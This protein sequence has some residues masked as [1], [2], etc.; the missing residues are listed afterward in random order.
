MPLRIQS[1]EIEGYKPFG[2]FKAELG[3]LEVI[4]G[5][6]SSGKSSLF[7]FLGFLKFA[8]EF[9]IP[10]EIVPGTIG[11]QI[12][13]RPGPD[14]FAWRVD[15]GELA[16]SGAV[17]GPLGAVK[18]GDETFLTHQSGA[19]REYVHA[20]ATRH[21][22]LNR[23]VERGSELAEFRDYVRAWRFY[24]PSKIDPAQ[25]RE[26]VLI[27]EEPE[28]S[29]NGRNLGAVLNFIQA[30]H[31]K[32]LNEIQAHLR[33]VIPGFR[34][35]AIKPRGGPGRVTL[36]WHEDGHAEPLTLADVSDGALRLLCWITLALHPE[37][38]PLICIDEPD[39]GAHPRALPL[40]AA[41]FQ[42]LSDRTQVLI[43]THSSYFLRQF[44]LSEIAI[45]RKEAGQ[46]V[47]IKPRDSAV[48][49]ANLEDFG[50]DGLERMH[51]SDE[52]E[53]LP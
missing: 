35:L 37:P 29:W 38:P 32:V 42:K 51:Q 3:P 52:L 5:A 8:A 47:F 40:L 2:K 27:D 21:L 31:P 22:S 7:E 26:P 12:F 41:L 28:L 10:S 33:S 16:Y 1:L 24:A 39:Q 17:L 49:V 34:Q 48:L 4:A 19:H 20:G 50:P 11:Q 53:R 14:K 13:H 6:N 25:A 23:D 46:A 15:V 45:M 30:D 9:E 36:F 44:D 18:V 43:S